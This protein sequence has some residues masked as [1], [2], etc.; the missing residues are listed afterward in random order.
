MYFIT[1]LHRSRTAW[2]AA[3]LDCI[4][5]PIKYMNQLSDLDM[6]FDK[7]GGISDSSLSFWIDDIISIYEPKTVIIERDIDD[8]KQSLKRLF[9]GIPDNPL[10][11]KLKEKMDS[12]ESPLILRVKYEELNDIN[13][14]EKIHN[15]IETEFN[16]DK[17]ERFKTLNIQTTDF[18]GMSNML[19]ELVKRVI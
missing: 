15:H 17:F 13:T 3:Y 9:P 1:G 16:V 8:V 5:E 19:I 6:Y 11:E 18:G 7:Y 14:M 2:M 10:M 12:V 4:H